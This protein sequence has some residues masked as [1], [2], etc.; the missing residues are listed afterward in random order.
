MCFLHVFLDVVL[1]ETAIGE[2]DCEWTTDTA[3]DLGLSVLEVKQLVSVSDEVSHSVIMT[4]LCTV[5]KLVLTYNE[6]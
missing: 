4:V 2:N 3:S 6:S 5:I 1:V